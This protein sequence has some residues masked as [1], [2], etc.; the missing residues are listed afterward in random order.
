MR[1]DVVEAGRLQ[2]REKLPQVSGFIPPTKSSVPIT[3]A[4]KLAESTFITKAI[5]DVDLNNVQ[6]GISQRREDKEILIHDDG[7]SSEVAGMKK[8]LVLQGREA[9]RG[10][11]PPT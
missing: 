8:T 7:R 3:R 2:R 1:P 10:R 11:R 9:P 4:R 6:R 5:A